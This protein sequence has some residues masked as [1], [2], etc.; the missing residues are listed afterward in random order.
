MPAPNGFRHHKTASLNAVFNNGVRKR[1]PPAPLWTTIR[2]QIG[3]WRRAPED[4]Q[5]RVLDFIEQPTQGERF[6]TVVVTTPSER[7]ANSLKPS[8]ATDRRARSIDYSSPS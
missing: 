1:R 2:R 3:R 6:T 4:P 5:S 7:N 8:E